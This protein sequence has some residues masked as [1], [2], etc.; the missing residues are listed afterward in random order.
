MA[1]GFL[2]PTHLLFIL[3]AL[4]VALGLRWLS[5]RDGRSA[6]SWQTAAAAGRLRTLRLRWPT[7]PQAHVAWVLIS[8][9]V[10]F[11]L[12]RAAALPLFL[13]VFFALWLCGFAVLVRLYRS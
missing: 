8:A 4:A 5:R 2:T 11:A 3:A 13:I 7:R 6:R 9:L 1:A 12:T 10:A